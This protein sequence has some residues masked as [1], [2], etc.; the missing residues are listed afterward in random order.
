MPARLT[1]LRDKGELHT[2]PAWE[3]APYA[4]HDVA[5]VDELMTE[6][7]PLIDAQEL[8]RVLELEQQIIPVV[9]EMEKNGASS[10]W[11]CSTQWTARSAIEYHDAM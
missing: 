11:T 1:R 8:E 6:T 10:T 7:D 3:V 4:M 9:V 2:L 5:L